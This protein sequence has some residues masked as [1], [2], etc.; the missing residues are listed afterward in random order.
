MNSYHFLRTGKKTCLT[1]TSLTRM[2]SVLDQSEEQI[3]EITTTAKNDVTLSCQT[4]FTMNA[5]NV[6]VTIYLTF[7]ELLYQLS[8]TRNPSKSRL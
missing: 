7:I 6:F 5:I 1:M 2:Q 8:D 4:N 3:L